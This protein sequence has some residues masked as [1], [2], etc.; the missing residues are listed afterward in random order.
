MAQNVK[1]D[2]MAV[3]LI[4]IMVAAML[5][6]TVAAAEGFWEQCIKKC[7]GGMDVCSPKCNALCKNQATTIPNSLQEQSPLVAT[8]QPP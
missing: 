6:P 1:N 2:T 4:A 8:S 3:L 7:K 5:P